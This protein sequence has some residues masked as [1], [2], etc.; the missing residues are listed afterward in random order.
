MTDKEKKKELKDRRKQ[1]KK[2]RGAGSTEEMGDLI[3]LRH[4]AKVR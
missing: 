4:K 1:E 2:M 3:G